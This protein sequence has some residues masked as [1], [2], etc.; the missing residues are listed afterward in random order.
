M[1]IISIASI[2]GGVGKTA[3]TTFLSQV[4]KG[5][6]LVIDADAN[7]NLTDYYLRNYTFEEINQANLYHLLKGE[8]I[9]S[10]V[11][12]N[13]DFGI[14]IIPCTLE[15]HKIGVEMSSNPGSMLKFA[16]NIKR[17]DYDYIFIDT[18]PSLSY[19]FRMSLHVSDL[20]LTPICFSRWTLQ[21]M[22]LLQAEIL[23]VQETFDSAPELL[24][25]PSIVTDK[26]NETLRHMDY[27]FSESYIKKSATIKNA[28][29]KATKI[30]DNSRSWNDFQLLAGEL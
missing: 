3:L 5:K 12:Y 26:E 17:L 1:K 13:T 2:K 6:T 18:P 15:L 16:R 24:A 14:D 28:H 21:A 25:V 9:P 11:I 8:V 22:L 7:N 20:V 19:E 29:D 30:K 10:D 4:V 27:N 23:E